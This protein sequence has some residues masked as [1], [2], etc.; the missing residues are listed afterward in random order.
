MLK[1]YLRLFV[2]LALFVLCCGAGLANGAPCLWQVQPVGPAKNIMNP[3]A[4]A[5]DELGNPRL[6]WVDENRQITYAAYQGLPG[7]LWLTETLSVQANYEVLIALDQNDAPNLFYPLPGGQ[8]GRSVRTASGWVDTPL[9]LPGGGPV[10]LDLYGNIYT[11]YFQG[12]QQPYDLVLAYFDGGQVLTETVEADLSSAF[13]GGWSIALDLDQQE[14]PHLAYVFGGASMHYAHK[15]QGTWEVSDV[16]R[17]SGPEFHHVDLEIDGNGVPHIA[18]YN[19]YLVH[20]QL[21]GTTWQN[22]LVD[23]EYI[24]VGWYPDLAIDDQ[25]HLHIGYIGT[26]RLP[27]QPSVRYAFWDGGQ[28][29]LEIASQ[30]SA[31]FTALALD[32]QGRPI[33]TYSDYDPYTYKTTVVKLA[34]AHTLPGPPPPSLQS[35][36]PDGQPGS[37]FRFSA[38]DFPAGEM[39]AVWA[40]ET[41]IGGGL[42]AA[43]DGSTAFRL[44]S[45]NALPGFYWIT[46]RSASAEARAPL[47]L[48]PGLPLRLSEGEDPLFFMAGSLPLN[49]VY[50]PFTWR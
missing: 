11:A 24:G 17:F 41:N 43:P 16:P 45:A 8:L 6:A 37:F 23:D 35:N 10:R 25:N 48:N 7:A 40:N 20:T 42:V 50:L 13:S 22:D 19:I 12:N 39:L 34:S 1:T 32:N 33:L 26:R 18:Y 31:M 9:P 4:I 29:S 3:V 28:W 47:I 15:L 21:N 36:Y 38:T 5:A 14:N 2:F 30:E 49:M 46:A 44:S 27:T